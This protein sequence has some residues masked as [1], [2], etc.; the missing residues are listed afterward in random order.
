MAT[1]PPGCSLQVVSPR[2]RSHADEYPLLPPLPGEL[3]GG[4]APP[5]GGPVQ[6]A[7]RAART[8]A[9]PIACTPSGQRAF[10]ASAHTWVVTTA[11]RV[12][13][14]EESDAVG[15]LVRCVE[16]APLVPSWKH[17]QAER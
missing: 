2:W 17:S 10:P 1:M 8:Q 11:W 4:W 3:E 14:V 13:I 9:G 16:T 6:R 5:G 7:G 12:T 15:V